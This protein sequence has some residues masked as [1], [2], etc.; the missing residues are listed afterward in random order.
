MPGLNSSLNI[1]LSGL[2]ATQSALS[3]IG[4]NISNVNT[5]GY[6]RQVAVLSTN[7]AQTFGDLQFGT[8]VSMASVQGVRN[9]FLDLQMVLANSTQSGADTRYSGVDSI[10]SIFEDDGTSGLGTLVQNFFNGF[11]KLATTPEDESMRTNVVG[12]AQNL[13][14]GLQSR[15]KLLEDQ[16]KQ[17][18]GSIESLAQQVNNLTEQIAELNVRVSGELSPGSDNDARDQ[19]QQLAQQLGS[20]VG[21]QIFENDQGHMQISLDS[22]AAVLVSGAS[23][24][25][26]SVTP[27][28]ALNNYFRVEVQQGNGT[29]INVTANIRNGQLGANLDLRDNVFPGYQRQLDELAAGLTGQVNLVHRTGFALNGV[30]T[31]LDFF[32]GVVANGADGLPTTI[33][34]ASNYQGMVNSMTINAAIRTNVNL[35]AA[36]GVAGSAGNNAVAKAISDLQGANATVDTNAD[37]IGDSGPY[38]GFLSSLLNRVGTDA[39]GFKVTSTNQ[40]NLLTALGN[41]RDQASAVDLDEEATNLITFQRGY[42]ACARFINVI[43]QLTDQLVNQFGQ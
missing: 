21:V 43:N 31:N 17:A 20:L 3:V 32:Q 9:R 35:I 6:S 14:N 18:N 34:A 7:G 15:Y 1:G 33:S 8:G 5:P 13:V 36:A 27:D 2:Q 30:T 4:H 12:Q 28:A 24:F 16:R 42:Q 39:Q 23:A 37:G 26:M 41:Q 11:Q 10:S 25:T 19:R 22:G 40:Q 38:N 29:P